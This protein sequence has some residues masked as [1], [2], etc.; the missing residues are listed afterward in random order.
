MRQVKEGL[1]I[2][3]VQSDQ[4]AI[5]RHRKKISNLQQDK[6]KESLKAA[7]AAKKCQAASIAAQK[8]KTSS[9]MRSKLSEARRQQDK[10]VK[11]EK[12][13][14]DIEKNI[15]QEQRLL[16]SAERRLIK[17]QAEA[18]RKRSNELDKKERE[19]QSRMNSINDRIDQHD[20]LHRV[21]LSTIK[22]LDNLPKQITVLFLASNP[23]NQNHLRLDEEVRSIGEMISKS[24]F[25]DAVKLESRWAT[26]PLDVL[27]AINDCQPTVIHFS[28]HG[29]NNEEIILQDNQGNAKPVSKEAIVQTMAA[30]SGDIQ[31][32]FFNTCY[33]DSQAEAI[34]ESVPAAIGM[35][36]SIS[37]EA[38]RIFAAQFYS[39]IGFGHSIKSAFDQA[40]AALMLESIPEESTPKLFII[41]GLN[42]NEFVL[43]DPGNS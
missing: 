4:R 26:R 38:A 5:E 3:S 1:I 14:A 33:S 12:K 13:N 17:T 36:M 6:S 20:E 31:L 24:K 35:H 32:V 43:I 27:Q 7:D 10:V 30:A 18:D 39:S 41:K 22:K 23:L 9:N 15:S 16:L 11:H 37:D 42:P 25:R 21:A 2:M 19:Y 34:V 8:S 29:S 40:K 28:G